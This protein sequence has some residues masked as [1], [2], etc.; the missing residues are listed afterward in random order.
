MVVLVVEVLPAVVQVEEEQV[1]TPVQVVTEQVKTQDQ[2]LQV[3][4]EEVL[5][6]LKILAE[7]E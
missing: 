7:A 2:Q 6:A 5:V 4:A 1:V 3:L